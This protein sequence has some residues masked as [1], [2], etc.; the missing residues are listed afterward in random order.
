MLRYAVA[1]LEIKWVFKPH[2][3]GLLS[4]FGVMSKTEVDDYYRRWERIELA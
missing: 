3:R 2:P 1:H 4:E